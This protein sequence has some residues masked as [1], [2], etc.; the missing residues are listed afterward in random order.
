[1]FMNH[2]FINV[3]ENLRL[4]RLTPDRAG[5]VFNITD[6]NRDYLGKFMP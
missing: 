6:K 3:D 2:E 5:E 1:M 4:E